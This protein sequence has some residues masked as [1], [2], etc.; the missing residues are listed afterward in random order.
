VAI[1]LNTASKPQLRENPVSIM[2]RTFSC[3]NFLIQQLPKIVPTYGKKMK[4][5][6]WKKTQIFQIQRDIPISIES[7]C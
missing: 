6:K 5:E 7:K 2:T 3:K 1:R 4:S